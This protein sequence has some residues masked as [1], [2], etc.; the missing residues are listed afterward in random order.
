MTQPVDPPR[1]ENFPPAATPALVC[2]KC[3]GGMHTYER[4]GIHI[5]QCGTCRGVFLDFGELEQLTQLEARMYAQ[6]PQSY[7]PPWAGGG[8]SR[9][10][11]GG[12]S[13]LFFSS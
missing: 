10:R 7:G 1:Y 8:H 13:G 2:P 3:R 4:N 9:G 5:E 11:R 6:P 12:L